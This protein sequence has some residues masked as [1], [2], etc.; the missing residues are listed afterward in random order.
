MTGLTK[1]IKSAV[2]KKT[3]VFGY[4]RVLKAL[5]SGKLKLIVHGSNIPD[6]MLKTIEHNAKIDKVVVKNFEKDSIEL[7]LTC[8]KPFPVS[9]LGIRGNGK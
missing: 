6:Y 5:K 1:T 7:G 3:V 4:E 9:I 8:G 2:N